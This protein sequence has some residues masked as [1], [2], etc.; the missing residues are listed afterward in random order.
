MK[1]AGFSF[2][3]IA[4]ERF[5]DSTGNIK[6]N[7]KIDVPNV[8][9]FL[10]TSFDKELLRAE[11]LYVLEYSSSFAKIELKGAV[12]FYAEKDEIKEVLEDWKKKKLSDSF[13]EVLFNIIL[14]KANIKALELEEELNL[15][16]HINLPSIKKK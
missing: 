11:F 12:L 10:A 5:S 4:A 16:F 1:L 7:T 15:P 14:R 9:K 6:I 8:E 3:K 13:Q 2:S